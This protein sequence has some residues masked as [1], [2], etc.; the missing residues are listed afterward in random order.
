MA[1]DSAINFAT[2][3]MRKDTLMITATAD[4]KTLKKEMT[5]LRSFLIGVAGKDGEGIYRPEFVNRVFVAM[6]DQPTYRFSNAKTF[7]EHLKT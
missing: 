6:N 1:L 3:Y 5:L 4:I 2:L 7:L